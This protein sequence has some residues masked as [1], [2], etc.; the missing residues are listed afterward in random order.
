MNTFTILHII[1]GYLNT[2][3]SHPLSL[4][5]FLILLFQ[6]WQTF[7]SCFAPWMFFFLSFGLFSGTF[8]FCLKYILQNSLQLCWRTPSTLLAWKCL[9]FA[10]ILQEYFY[11]LQDSK[12]T[13]VE[14]KVNITGPRLLSLERTAYKDGPWLASGP[15]DFRRVPIIP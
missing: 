1:Q 7:L 11:W 10:F 13:V 3:P 12:S 9:H 2:L 14:K 5:L 4:T 6:A 15:L 8:S